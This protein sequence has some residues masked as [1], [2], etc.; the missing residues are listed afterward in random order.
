MPA[1]PQSVD[2]EATE[3]GASKKASKMFGG[4]RLR[5][6]ASARDSVDDID[7][8]DHQQVGIADDEDDFDEDVVETRSR[9]RRLAITVAI[10]LVFASISVYS[11]FSGGSKE[12]TV[13]SLP[14]VETQSAP[15]K[16]QPESE[17]GIEVP[18][19]DKQVLN[20]TTEESTKVERLLSPPELPN[21]PVMVAAP[22][23]TAAVASSEPAAEEPS[24]EVAAVSEPVEETPA[25]VT[26]EPAPE[27]ATA[28]EP[29]PQP[30]PEPQP[31]PVIAEAVVTPEPEE[32][33]VVATPASVTTTVAPKDT[34]VAQ[35]SSGDYVLQLSSMK[36][37]DAAEGAW[38]RIQRGHFD[39][40]GDM[41]LVVESAEVNGTTYYRVQTGP[42]PSKA[43]A[44]DMCAQLK[45]EGQ[46]CL[47]KKR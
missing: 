4:A 32:P 29:E 36:S 17:G 40:L 30:A 23:E 2:T 44:L 34:Q 45:A 8:A 19:Q 37:A 5:L 28:P 10:L 3:D 35:V 12:S 6:F 1:D 26:E 33:A 43:T 22:A 15:V 13:A 16:V 38:G 39:L 7:E 46:D 18:H 11:F 21:P 41:S 14:V 20:G 25:V 24:P 42:F 27:V 9:I 31:E 47:V